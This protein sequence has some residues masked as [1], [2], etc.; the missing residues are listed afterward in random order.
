MWG[1]SSI[2]RVACVISQCGFVLL[3]QQRMCRVYCT[4]PGLLSVQIC[5]D[6]KCHNKHGGISK[7]HLPVRVIRWV[8]R[9]SVVTN[10]RHKQA[11]VGHGCGLQEIWQHC[12]R[13]GHAC[14]HVP[15]MIVSLARGKQERHDEQ[16]FL[17]K[18]ALEETLLIGLH[19]DIATDERT[20]LESTCHDGTSSLNTLDV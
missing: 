15:E 18:T 19:W 6:I 2:W 11:G 3:Q 16:L 4:T 13:A 8:G 5:L 9:C 17:G 12:C 14:L 7:Q 10:A 20:S 1:V